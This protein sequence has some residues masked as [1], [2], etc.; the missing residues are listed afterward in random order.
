MVRRII[1]IVWTI[2]IKV[3]RILGLPDVFCVSSCVDR[4]V[5]VREEEVEER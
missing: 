2:S 4:N 5:A 1:R 3:Q